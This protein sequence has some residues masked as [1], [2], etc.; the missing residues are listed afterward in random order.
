[1]KKLKRLYIGEVLR[2]LQKLPSSSVQCVVTS[3][4]YYQLRE[5][6]IPS[7]YWPSVEYI[8]M[9]GLE[10]IQIPPQLCQLGMEQREL[11]FI[12]HMVLIFREVRRVLHDN[13][14]CFVNLS[15]GYSS[16]K[17][18]RDDRKGFYERTHGYA[19]KVVDHCAAIKR[20]SLPPKNLMGIPWRV[21]LALQADGWY[22]RQD[23]IWAKPNPMPESCSDRCT[24]AHEYIFMLSKQRKYKWNKNAI[25]TERK[26]D[27]DCSSFRGGSYAAG[28]LSSYNVP[29]GWDTEKRSHGSIHKEGRGN[30]RKKVPASGKA[31]RRS[32]WT[33]STE[34]FHQAH[35]ATFPR[36]LPRLC[37]LAS[38]DLGDTVL[39]IF[40][41]SG[42][43]CQMADELGREWIGI[44]RDLRSIRWTR[45][46][47]YEKHAREKGP[48][49]IPITQGQL[50]LYK[51]DA[52]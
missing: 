37:I 34:A 45:K 31:N 40:N 12:G 46:R 51:R 26:T 7:S 28:N 29:N 2:N 36:E 25:A 1:M 6:P 42:T 20:S 30:S 35:Y 10:P 21:A 39:D 3:P 24:K 8:P 23:I 48:E 33:F 22:L 5:Y 52:D 9:H 18:G 11:D 47:I 27:N 4:P 17:N 15:D 43:T 44:D 41:G 32:V 49:A 14:V 16:G 38:T 13:G 50:A 19:G